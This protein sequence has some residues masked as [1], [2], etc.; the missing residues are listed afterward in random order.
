MLILPH[1]CLVAIISSVIVI[2]CCRKHLSLVGF[3]YSKRAQTCKRVI[4]TS[5]LWELLSPPSTPDVYRA[6]RSIKGSGLVLVTVG[7]ASSLLAL[8]DARTVSNKCMAKAFSKAL[9]WSWPLLP[10]SALSWSWP[11]LAPNAVNWFVFRIGG[12]AKWAR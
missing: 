4:S 2:C 6:H 12:D 11:L 7:S 8:D 3:R 5:G 1:V 10:A 9:S